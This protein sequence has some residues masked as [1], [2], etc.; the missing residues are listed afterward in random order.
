MLESIL[1]QL[2]KHVYY[3][4]SYVIVKLLRGKHQNKVV[5]DNKKKKNEARATQ[6]IQLRLLCTRLS[7][8][9]KKN[10]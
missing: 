1:M 10:N 3:F 8:A 5:N 9:S 2:L 4:A 6:T 7:F